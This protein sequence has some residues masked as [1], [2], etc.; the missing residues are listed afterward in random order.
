MGGVNGIN[1]KYI[2]ASEHE[3]LE[4]QL[5]EARQAFADEVIAL[6]TTEQY[7][8]GRLYTKHV[9]GINKVCN[10]L[11]LFVGDLLKKPLTASDGGGE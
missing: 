5:G 9:Y 3:A 11:K 4:R 1:P 10:R 7:A 6:I 8:M 2:L